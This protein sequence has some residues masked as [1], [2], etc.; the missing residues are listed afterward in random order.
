M[1]ATDIVEYAVLLAFVY[2]FIYGPMAGKQ[3]VLYIAVLGFFMFSGTSWLLSGGTP[4]AKEYGRFA[5]PIQ[6]IA[7]LI[8]MITM[9]YVWLL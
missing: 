2:T 5:L 1:R 7:I 8:G 6:A 9:A 4:A 3:L